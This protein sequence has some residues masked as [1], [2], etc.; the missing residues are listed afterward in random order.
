MTKY[1]IVNGEGEEVAVNY[2]YRQEAETN[3]TRLSG[4]YAKPFHV[5]EYEDDT[6]VIVRVVR[7]EDDDPADSWKQ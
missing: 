3:A 6:K 5:V 2:W 4:M 7:D 1:K